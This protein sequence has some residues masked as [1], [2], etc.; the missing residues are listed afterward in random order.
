MGELDRKKIS[1]NFSGVTLIGDRNGIQEITVQGYDDFE[2]G[3]C[4]TEDSNFWVCSISKMFTSIAINQLCE[5]GILNKNDLLNKYIPE[6]FKGYD[7]NIY[8]LLTHTSGIPNYIM[9]QKEIDWKSAH[10]SEHILSVVDGKPLKFKPGTKWS[11]CNTGYYLLALIVE[12]VTHMKYEDYIQKH[13]FD[14]AQMRHS[15]FVTKQG[16]QVVKPHIK[17]SFSYA[18]HP[19]ML[20]GA[21]DVVS[22]VKDLYL[23]GKAI[24]EGKLVS[25]DTLKAMCTPVFPDKKIHYGE[26]VF[27]NNHFDT[28]MMGHSGSVPTGYSSQLSIYPE[29]GIISIVLMNN[30]K[31]L[32]PLVY[33]DANAKYM[34]SCLVEQLFQKKIGLIKKAYI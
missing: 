25:K 33:V 14:V 1:K 12:Q 2:K 22:N 23:F 34:D 30:R 9:Y 28:P 6:Y 11:Y 19:S 4:H 24:M 15:S 8:H 29:Q 31:V 32:H 16:I 7:I 18:F 20:F 21:G 10:T 5:Q 26:G 27:L 17:D 3:V 13:V